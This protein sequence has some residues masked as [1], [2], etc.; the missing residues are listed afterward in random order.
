MNKNYKDCYTFITE[1][2]KTP[3]VLFA[4]FS[5]ILIKYP[6]SGVLHFN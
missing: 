3:V 1:E 5:I 4:L 6:S 2:N